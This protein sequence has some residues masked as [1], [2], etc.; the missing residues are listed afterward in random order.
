MYRGLPKGGISFQYLAGQ[1][2]IVHLARHLLDLHRITCY[3][4]KMIG[5]RRD[6]FLKH[7]V[8]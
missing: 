2:Q 4:R 7:A 5:P 3:L 8:F 1:T 6:H